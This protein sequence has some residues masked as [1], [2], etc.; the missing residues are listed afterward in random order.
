MVL[1]SLVCD[2]AASRPKRAA[3]H[4]PFASAHQSADNRSAHRRP[5][6]HL[7]GRVVP[8]IAGSLRRNCM[9][10]PALRRTLLSVR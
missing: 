9:P 6:D 1:A 10:V 7:R 4:S 5:A 8:V 2:S 3:D